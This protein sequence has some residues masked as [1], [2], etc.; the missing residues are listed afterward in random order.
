M[1]ICYKIL[2]NKYGFDDFN[3]YVIANLTK[4]TGRILWKAGDE[5]II[6]GGLVN[7]IAN[8]IKNMSNFVKKIQTGR[9]YNYVYIMIT[10]FIILLLSL[11]LN[12]S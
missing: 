9:L 3:Q 4:R 1:N 11:L 12:F 2:N 10:G 8:S 6:D 7:G 5:Y